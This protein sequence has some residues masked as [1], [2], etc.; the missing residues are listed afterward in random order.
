MSK[1]SI[2]IIAVVLAA[3]SESLDQVYV[4]SIGCQ[5]DRVG[6]R[7]ILRWEETNE[8]WV[9]QGCRP[10]EFADYVRSPNS[11]LGIISRRNPA[12]ISPAQIGGF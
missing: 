4:D 3:C 2:F 10:E 7:L 1:I 12:I 11:R 9:E 8:G 5:Y 6:A